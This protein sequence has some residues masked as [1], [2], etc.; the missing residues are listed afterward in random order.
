[1]IIEP[2]KRKSIL[3]PEQKLQRPVLPARKLTPGE[4][5][6]K[7]LKEQVGKVPVKSPFATPAVAADAIDEYVETERA[8]RL[9]KRVT[10]LAIAVAV[11]G[12]MLA[13]GAPFFKPIYYY[14]TRTPEGKIDSIWGLELPNL[15]NPAI[16]S[17]A[18]TSTTEVLSFGFGDIEQ[19][20]LLQKKRFTTPAWKSFVNVYENDSIIESFKKSQIAQTTVPT[21][22]AVIKAQGVNKEHVYEWKVDVPIITT[23]IANN[24]VI[25]P[26]HGTIEMTIVRVSPND[27]PAGIAIDIW[28]QVRK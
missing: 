17:W 5:A 10:W 13:L 25:K 4:K 26:V 23:Y 11:F 1:M 21:D 7:Y 28:R 27:N 19:V 24:N 12:I 16:A 3:P 15:T 22:V 20:S 18:A 14:F 6:G 8:D 2:E 9:L